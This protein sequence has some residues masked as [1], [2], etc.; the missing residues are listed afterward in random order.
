MRTPYLASRPARTGSSRPYSS[1]PMTS[2][3]D[4][5]KGRRLDT[6]ASVAQSWVSICRIRAISTCWS[7]SMCWASWK[8]F[9]S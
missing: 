1:H 5:S 8:T 6:F 2:S 4:E 9:G 3:S 7:D